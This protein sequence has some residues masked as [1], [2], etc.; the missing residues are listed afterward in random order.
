MT[1]D[2]TIVLVDT[3]AHELSRRAIDITLSRL[4]CK[5][6]VVFSD[7]NIFPDGRWIRTNSLTIDD[8]NL[9]M[10]KHLWLH[11][12]TEHALV[13]QYDGMAAIRD[14]WDDQFLEYDYIGAI[15]PWAHHPPN[16]KVG[17]GGFSLRSQRLL[18]LLKDDNVTFRPNLL[19]NE[20]LYI[21]VYYKDWLVSNGV[22]YPSIELAEKFS[23]E[24]FPGYKPSFGFHGSFN[25]PYYLN[26][27]DSEEFVRYLP[28]R[29]SESSQLMALHF[30]LGGRDELG[31][32]AIELARKEHPNF[33]DMLKQTAFKAAQESNNPEMLEIIKRI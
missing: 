15:W 8:Y 30:L 2:I 22:K 14:H 12:H 13:V 18:N 32:L 5:E 17:N 31:K 9:I 10:L 28:N 24:Q 11:V 33:V 1:K 19:R 29:V 16:L 3:Y 6:V 27:Y 20:D 23:H 21:G 26:D 7:R 25:V 4:P